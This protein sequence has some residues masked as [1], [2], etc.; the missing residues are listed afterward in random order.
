MLPILREAHGMDGLSCGGMDRV[1]ACL[2]AAGPVWPM[3][4]RAVIVPHGDSPGATA[5]AATA[6]AALHGMAGRIRRVV[7]IGATHG[8]RVR[9]LAVPGDAT[10]GD[11]LGPLPVD[12][13]ACAVL[14]AL[15]GVE[16]LDNGTIAAEPAI[17]AQLPFLLRVLGPAPVVPVLVGATAGPPQVAEALARV[18]DGP[19]TLVVVSS[20]LSRGLDDDQA[21][22]LDQVTAGLIETLEDGGLEGMMA[23]G[24]R[25][26][27]GMLA[28]GRALDLRATALD[29]RTSADFGDGRDH[30][31]GFGAFALEDAAT[32]RLPA[33]LRARLLEAVHASLDCT[34]R[35]G[36]PPEVAVADQPRPIQAR[37]QTF[38]TLELDGELRGCIGSIEPV[39]PLLVDVV[40]NA[41]KAAT[42][43]P[44][45]APL[46]AAELPRIKPT[47]SVLSTARPVAFGSE[48]ELIAALVPGR[49]GLILRD[50]SRCGLFLPKVWDLVPEPR[51]F[52]AH[53]KL[54]AGLP[55]HHWSDQVQIWRFSAETF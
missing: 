37:R 16:G 22:R 43:D 28:H 38:V 17:A 30:V 23:C 42:C 14:L 45:F 5:V 7:V 35:T 46:T 39:S 29:L 11:A 20:D 9:G 3:P 18:A 53:L 13:S 4:A 50:G 47:I 32:A 33:P 27:G 34:V 36:R 6:Y 51:L 41:H 19:E 55:P 15:P 21:R 49:D 12:R 1:D 48:A 25:A 52:L 54:K 40:E 24:Y 2:A 26:I 8:H 10:R 44:R 31:I